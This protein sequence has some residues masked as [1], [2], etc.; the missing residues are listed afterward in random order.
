MVPRDDVVEV[1]LRM[2]EWFTAVLAL[3]LVSFKNVLT[4]E[5]DLL[6]GQAI[7]KSQYDHPGQ[8]YDVAHGVKAFQGRGRRIFGYPYPLV[9]IIQMKIARLP[10]YHVGMATH[11]EAEGS[12]DANYIDRLPKTVEHQH[13]TGH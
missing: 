11:Q 12:L 10:V 6:D 1:Q 9:E 5:F 7:K 4:V 3:K 13:L 8:P 2:L